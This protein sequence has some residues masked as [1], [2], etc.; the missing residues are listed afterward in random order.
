MAMA[1][2]GFVADMQKALD[3]DVLIGT[4]L[5]DAD[6]DYEND[7]AEDAL[8]TSSVAAGGFAGGFAGGLAGGLM[9]VPE[10]TQVEEDE[11]E[12]HD[13]RELELLNNTY[14]TLTSKTQRVMKNLGEQQ[15]MMDNYEEHGTPF[16]ILKKQH[17]SIES[18]PNGE[19]KVS[20]IKTFNVLTAV[21]SECRK[22]PELRDFA[23]RLFSQTSDYYAMKEKKKELNQE[24]HMLIR[25]RDEQ[26][27]D[28]FK[29]KQKKRIETEKAEI[30]GKVK[31]AK[32]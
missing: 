20:S 21:F 29:A 31:R 25:L 19:E 3:D 5:T 28:N 22:N 4:G 9:A 27:I 8:A 7:L 2:T 14:S 24:L 1:S 18:M 13:D 12:R 23:G 26:E 32:I 16:E 10:A 17:K 15:K 11:E 6:I 30:S